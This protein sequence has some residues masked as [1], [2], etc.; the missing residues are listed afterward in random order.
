MLP[1]LYLFQTLVR[2]A[3]Y[4]ARALGSSQRVTTR[5]YGRLSIRSFNGSNLQ[6]EAARCP[7]HTPLRSRALPPAREVSP[8][9]AGP[10]DPSTFA[11]QIGSTGGYARSCRWRRLGINRSQSG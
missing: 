11:V 2:S 5:G 3:A 9:A 8:L 7:R 10:T 4:I 1:S 6:I